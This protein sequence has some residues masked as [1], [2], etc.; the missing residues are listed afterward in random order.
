MVFQFFSKPDRFQFNP[1]YHLG[2][3]LTPNHL[4][5]LILTPDFQIE[6]Q[7]IKPVPRF[8]V[9]LVSGPEEVEL[10]SSYLKETLGSW[11]KSNQA[12]KLPIDLVVCPPVAAT[13]FMD[14]T[15][16]QEQEQED[17]LSEIQ[18]KLVE[19]DILRERS[20]FVKSDLIWQ[21]ESQ[22]AFAACALDKMP[23]RRYEKAFVKAG[24]RIESIQVLPLALAAGF[25][26]S[27]QV[28]NLIQ[29]HGKAIP[30]A[31]ASIVAEQV[32]V[33]LWQGASLLYLQTIPLPRTTRLLEKK[34]IEV[35]LLSGV[36]YPAIWFIWKE[37]YLSRNFKLD[38]LNL[39]APAYPL[40]LGPYYQEQLQ[41]NQA[42]SNSEHQLTQSDN[43]LNLAYEAPYVLPLGASLKQSFS[44][45]FDWDFASELHSSVL[46]INR[47]FV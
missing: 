9:D 32:C 35:A 8:L 18:D 42:Q 1:Q 16:Y 2:V 19:P 21:A 5:A 12:E 25:A 23:L 15:F 6:A 13:A 33:Q 46:S 39:K 31:I 34:L 24:L 37:P 27:G 22:V 45:G 38:S 26:A 11:L 10:L 30:W 40:V 3:C 14:K 17:V 47:V 29:A 36:S 28:D 41:A 7:L 20:P 4:S 44:I 43:I